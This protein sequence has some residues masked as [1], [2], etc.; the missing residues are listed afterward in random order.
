MFLQKKAL[1]RKVLFWKIRQNSGGF[2]ASV[3]IFESAAGAGSHVADPKCR[4]PWL[5]IAPKFDWGAPKEDFPHIFL[6]GPK[7]FGLGGKSKK[8]KQL[9]CCPLLERAGG[10]LV[11]L[12]GLRGAVGKAGWAGK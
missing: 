8:S 9:F 3:G 4:V 7:F 5:Q 12:P 10:F 6:T 11:G 1:F 2:S